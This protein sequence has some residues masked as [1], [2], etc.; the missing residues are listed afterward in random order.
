MKV[1]LKNI[2]Y[3]QFASEETSCFQATVYINGKRSLIARNDG[4]GGCNM[5]DPISS[6]AHTQLEEYAKSLPE[7]EFGAGMK[8]SYQPDADTVIEDLLIASL[9]LKDMKRA[10]KKQIL[11][12]KPG[13]DAVWSFSC[14]PTADN[15]GTIL[16]KNP[17]YKLLNIMP[18][19]EA[20]AA[21]QADLSTGSEA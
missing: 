7:R 12:V 19:D 3:A 11:F 20:L 4:R 1:E 17:T 6:G 21:W 13:S 2:K 5:Y 16:E 15:I 9:Y 8:G 18:E 10:L 14:K